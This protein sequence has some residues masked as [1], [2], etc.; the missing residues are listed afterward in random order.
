MTNVDL[1]PRLAYDHVMHTAPVS[2][3]RALSANSAASNQ[4]YDNMTFVVS[5]FVI[6]MSSNDVSV[7]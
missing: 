3:R 7:I 4:L 6:S 5:I 2:D 1:M